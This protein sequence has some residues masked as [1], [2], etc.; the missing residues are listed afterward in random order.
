[1]GIVDVVSVSKPLSNAVRGLTVLLFLFSLSPVFAV[2]PDS[3]EVKQV[4]ERALTWLE[5]QDDQRLGGK[6]LIGLSFYK[7]G[8]SLSHPKIVAAKEACQAALSGDLASSEINYSNRK[9][10]V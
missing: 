2:S 10:V 7:A 1:M 9:S 8:R 3:P 5:T 6:C 4:T